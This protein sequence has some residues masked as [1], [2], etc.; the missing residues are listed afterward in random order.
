MVRFLEFCPR[1]A[2]HSAHRVLVGHSSLLRLCQL[3]LHY[4]PILFYSDTCNTVMCE[5]LQHFGDVYVMNG[6]KHSLEDNG[7]SHLRK[8]NT[9]RT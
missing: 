3:G 9:K 5:S 4:R 7:K 1:Y 6:K 8:I 2:D